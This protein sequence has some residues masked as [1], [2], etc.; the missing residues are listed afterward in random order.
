MYAR[1]YSGQAWISPIARQMLAECGAGA[2]MAAIHAGNGAARIGK[3]V[4]RTPAEHRAAVKKL[5]KGE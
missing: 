4:L 5:G 2:V 1:A 3:Y